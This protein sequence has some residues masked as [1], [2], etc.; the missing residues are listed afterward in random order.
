M[1]KGVNIGIAN[2]LR[3]IMISEIPILSID[4]VQFERNDSLLDDEFIAHRLGM[5]VLDSSALYSG[6]INAN[7]S[8][9]LTADVTC[10]SYDPLDVTVDM[11]KSNIP[12]VPCLYPD[13]ILTR[14]YK[15]Q[16][17][18]FSAVAKIGIGKDHAKWNSI[19]GICME[20]E[21]KGIKITM[22]ETGALNAKD[23]IRLGLTLL[24]ENM[25]KLQ[26]LM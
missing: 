4:T 22:E 11:I 20:P 3:R 14:L 6:K 5:V 1:L 23:I 7:T 24:S 26:A 10:N 15:G 25:L 19:S 8:I 16:C 17:L 18:K 2:S 13:T 9:I 12:E 21:E